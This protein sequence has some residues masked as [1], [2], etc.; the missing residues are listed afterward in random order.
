MPILKNKIKLTILILT[1]ASIVVSLALAIFPVFNI[2]YF[3]SEINK[4]YEFV[5]S[6]KDV[7]PNPKSLLNVVKDRSYGM[8]FTNSNEFIITKRKLTFLYN[9]KDGF[10]SFAVYYFERNSIFTWQIKNI[11][12]GYFNNTSYEKA[13]AIAQKY[14]L[15]KENPDPENITVYKQPTQEEIDSTKKAQ[16]VNSNLEFRAE[17]DKCS[18]VNLPGTKEEY[19]CIKAVESKFGL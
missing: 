12:K 3:S 19:D 16:G 13:V 5:Q 17:R 8:V 10:V 15:S 7:N 1:V 9:A 6:E 2:S 4:N 14:D 11:E 18:V